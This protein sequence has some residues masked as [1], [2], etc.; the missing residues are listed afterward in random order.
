MGPHFERGRLLF[1]QERH[2]MAIR[3]FELELAEDPD[4]AHVHAMLALCR[5]AKQEHARAAEHARRAIELAP[6]AAFVHYVYAQVALG[7]ERFA[8]ALKSLDEAIRLDADDADSHALRAAVLLRQEKRKEALAAA[9]QALELDAENSLAQNIRASALVTLGRASEARAGLSDALERRPEDAFTHANQGWTL[10]HAG[11]HRRAIEHFGEALRLDPT[12]GWAKDGLLQAL[13]ARYVAYRWMLAFYL[14]Q[15]R[16][17]SRTR[18]MLILGAYFGIRLLNSAADKNPALEPLV[19]PL[20]IAYGAFVF[21]TWTADALF[22]LAIF[23]NRHAR[24]LLTPARHATSIV[25]FVVL[26]VA[27]TAG[28]LAAA[29]SSV[30]VGWGAAGLAVTILPISIAGSRRAGWPRLVMGGYCVV[31][32]LLVALIVVAF[33]L[34][35]PPRVDASPFLWGVIGAGLSTWIGSFLPRGDGHSDE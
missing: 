9:E 18:W 30:T 11:D 7:T 34:A 2:D 23:C 20:S 21:L 22:D 27:A 29:T 10:L 28:I 6:D 4:Q 19:A 33:T 16:L 17:T 14:W 24:H 3:E 8:D 12:D 1:E 5:R 32:V 35:T 26:G 15:G 13:K 25:L 31:L